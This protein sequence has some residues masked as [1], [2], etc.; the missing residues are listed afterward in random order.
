MRLSDLSIKP[1]Y[2]KTDDDIAEEFYLPCMRCSNRY[3]RISGYFGSTIILLH[4]ML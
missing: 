2:T 1:S 4:G 3:D